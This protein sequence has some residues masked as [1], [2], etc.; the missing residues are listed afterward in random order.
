M[1]P[2]LYTHLLHSPNFRLHPHPTSWGIRKGLNQDGREGKH[3][4]PILVT[5]YQAWRLNA[6]D[7]GYLPKHGER[8]GLRTGFLPA[9]V[10]IQATAFLS[11]SSH[12]QSMS[13]ALS[14]SQST[15]RTVAQLEEFASCTTERDFP[16]APRLRS[17]TA[18][19]A[20][21]LRICLPIQGIWVRFLVRELRSHVLRAT[22]P[23]RSTARVCALQRKIPHNATK[24]WHSQ[25]N[26]YF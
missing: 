26:K 8:W 7:D 13:L 12:S 19:M 10:W 1:S 15:A 6:W 18:L 21:W 11:R 2:S 25:I 14:C 22:K 24:T 16:E 20:R 9:W 5:L 4:D 17:G 23:V 3:G